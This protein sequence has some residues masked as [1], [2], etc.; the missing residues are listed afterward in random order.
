MGA[1]QIGV[2]DVNVIEVPVGLHLGL[3]GLH[4]FAFT[5]DLVVHLDA[6]DFLEGLG[7]H[8]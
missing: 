8:G 3:H 5:E 4:D 7:Q 1:D 2:V 6:G